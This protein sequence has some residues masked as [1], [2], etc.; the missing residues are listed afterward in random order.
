MRGQ[1]IQQKNNPISWTKA[2]RANGI[3]FYVSAE[4][5]PVQG[6]SPDERHGS[7][8]NLSSD[9]LLVIRK[10]PYSLDILE[11]SPSLQNMLQS[12]GQK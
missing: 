12:P 11:V 9:L 2:V 10:V 3:I 6:Q 5:S 1:N 8:V 7:G 4:P